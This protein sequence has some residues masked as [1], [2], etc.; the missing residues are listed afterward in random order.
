MNGKPVFSVP[1][2]QVINMDSGFKPKLLCDGPTF[3]LGSACAYSCA[4]CYVE[5][6]MLKNPHW[7]GIKDKAPGGKF[8]NVVIRRE[9]ALA[10]MQNQLTTRGKPRYPDPKD[11]RVIYSSPLVDAAANLDLVAETVEACRLILELTHWQIR[12]LS[13]S[14]FLPRIAMRI[15]G[16]YADRM[17][18]G[19]S[20]GTMDDKLA[21]SFEQGTPPPSARIKSLR[22][23]QDMGM[24]TY[25][26]LCPSLPLP[27][28]T[29]RDSRDQREAYI[30]MAREMAAAIRVEKCEH[31]WAEVI[32]VRGESMTRTCAALREAGYDAHADELEFV[33][34]NKPA[35]ERYA[36]ET[37]L[38]HSWFIPQQ[39]LRFLQYA[40]KDTK[41]WWQSRAEYG[42]VLLGNSAHA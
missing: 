37:F 16:Q 12:L 38:A 24:R 7:Q 20:T 35:W 2:K 33:S 1:A 30:A 40:T 15:P 9:G 17:I 41:A 26:M 10:A 32:N 23:L 31:V 34:G 39:K 22:E 5:A 18:Y 29:T 25:G 13:K 42:A 14:T 8:E 28:G 4:F 36:R 21:K 3:S 11:N 19:V 6:M 27:V